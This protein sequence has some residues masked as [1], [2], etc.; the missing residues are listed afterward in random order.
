MRYNKT[1]PEFQ[2]DNVRNILKTVFLNTNEITKFEKI[3]NLAKV[4]FFVRLK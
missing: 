1:F 3:L 4:Y 2:S